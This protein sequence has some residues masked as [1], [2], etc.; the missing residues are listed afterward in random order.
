MVQESGQRTDERRPA[1]RRREAA[2]RIREARD[3][4]ATS[5]DQIVIDYLDHALFALNQL[6]SSEPL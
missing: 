6:E 4:L 5:S 3:M 2:R 1:S